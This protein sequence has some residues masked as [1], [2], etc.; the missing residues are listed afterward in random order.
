MVTQKQLDKLYEV[1][2]VETIIA[3]AFSGF[4]IFS[5]LKFKALRT[6]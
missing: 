5:Y 3:L 1:T 2:L 6:K 4:V